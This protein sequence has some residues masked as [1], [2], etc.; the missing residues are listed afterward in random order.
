MEDPC[1]LIRNQTTSFSWVDNIL[2]VGND[3]SKIINELKSTFKIKDL[4][5]ESHVLGMQIVQDRENHVLINQTHY[6]NELLKKYNMKYCKTTPTPIQIN[7]KLEPFKD[8]EV[9]EFKKLNLDYKA[10]IGSLNYTSQCTH[11]DISYAVGHLSKFLQKPNITHWNTFKR[12]LC[13]L[14][15]TKDL[16]I[17]Y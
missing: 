1:L 9:D 15:G 6:I 14:K 16:G 4:G 3:S 17:N 10:A 8:E 12:I 13:Y 11:P 2:V 7:N 5:L